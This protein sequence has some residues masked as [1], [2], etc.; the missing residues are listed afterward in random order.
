M[1]KITDASV[2]QRKGTPDA[3]GTLAP[4][5]GGLISTL[6]SKPGVP[7]NIKGLLF[8]PPKTG[9]T[10]VACSGGTTLLIEFDPDGAGTE[11]LYG[12]DDIT[13]VRP[14][15]YGETIGVLNELLAG[16][17]A[18]Y[19]WVVIDSLTF[20]FDKLAGDDINN[21]FL[22]NK[23]VRRAYGKAG[24]AVNSIVSKAVAL[25]TNVIFIAH[26]QVNAND[27]DAVTETQ[28]GDHEVK[29]AVSPMIWRNLGPAVG[30]I[31]RTYRVKRYE[32]DAG[33]KPVAVNKFMVSFN[34]GDRSPAGSRYSMNG[35]YEA[36][37]MTLKTVQADAMKGKI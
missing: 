15:N 35:E 19:D 34:D 11:T 10:T 1:P 32:K 23:D 16:A 3:T 17:Y 14:E 21:T 37:D 2:K 7:T 27:D 29:V 31:G 8:G 36:N 26:L 28:L 9:K 13:V 22:Q 18:D 30:F 20:L 25:K 33:G 5:T 24:A 4:K 12:R 6:A